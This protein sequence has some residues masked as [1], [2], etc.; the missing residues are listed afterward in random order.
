MKLSIPSIG[1][2][3]LLFASFPAFFFGRAVAQ[4]TNIP[5]RITQ[6]IN[7]KN[8]VVLR[9]NVHPLARPEFDQGL[10]ADAQPLKRMLLL[11][12]R[13]PDQESDLRQL[14]DDQQSKSSPNYHAWLTPEQFGK[15]FGPTDADIQAVMQ[16]L[17]SRGFTAIKVEP[18]RTVIEFSGTVGNVRNAFR[19]EIHRYLVAGVEHMANASDPQIPA[20]LRPAIA[21]IVSL[22]DFRKKPMYH[23]AGVL[24]ASKSIELTGPA[25]PEYS[26]NCVDFFTHV[27][28][29]FSGQSTTCHPLGPYDFA[30][31]YNVLP[32]WSATPPVD[33]AGQSIAIVGRTNINVEDVNDFR[34]LFGLPANPPQVILDGPDP[35]LVRGDETYADLD[36]EWSGAVAKGATIKLVVSQSTETTDGVDLSALYIVDHNLAPAMSESYGQC[37][38]N[39]GA[40]GNQLY[41]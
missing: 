41:T 10:V 1:R 17:T 25:V 40:A 31:I 22:H 16:W 3:V 6:A 13:S 7:E 35:G 30:T 24:N 39:M 4:T 38:F 26:F 36:V 8:L 37:E 20:A 29:A 33:G 2:A 18:G 23:L 12:Q 15:Q 9:G 27:F 19:S 28:G 32:L 21:G 11:L 5:A 34:N 14:L